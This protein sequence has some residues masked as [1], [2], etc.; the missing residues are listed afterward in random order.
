MHQDGVQ[1]TDMKRMG[2]SNPKLYVHKDG[3]TIMIPAEKKDEYMAKGYKLSSLRA[4]DDNS[5]KGMNKYG[6]AA[7]NKDGKFYS[8]RNGK[9]TGTF[10]NMADLQKHQHDLIKDESIQTEDLAQMAQKVEQDHEVQMARSDLYKAAKY[11]IKLHERLKGISEE[12]GLEGWVAAKITKASDYLSSVYH[13]MDYEMM[14]EE[15]Y[16]PEGWADDLRKLGARG[17]DKMKALYD[18][19]T[20]A[21]VKADDTAG[22]DAGTMFKDLTTVHAMNQQDM[23]KGY[24]NNTILGYMKKYIEPRNPKAFLDLSKSATPLRKIFP[25]GQKTTKQTLMTQLQKVAQTMAKVDLPGVRGRPPATQGAESIDYKETISKK[26]QTKLD[27]VSKKKTEAVL[28]D[29][30]GKPITEEE[31]EKLAEKQDA[32]Y[33]KV[34]ARYKVW[35]SAYASGALVQCRKKGAANWGN[36]SKK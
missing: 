19:A 23:T 31:F 27:E 35:P 34:K 33:H 7:K 8:Y 36:K 22:A 29:F 18:P 2:Q 3:K 28:E 24:D 14:S 4:E 20:A 5:S 1:P 17:L 25:V 30:V 12:E 32:C 10:D 11:S 16:L 9:L 6:L 21:K 15:T 26:Y 13:Y